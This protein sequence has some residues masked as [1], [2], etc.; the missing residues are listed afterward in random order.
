M[1]AAAFL[2]QEC[3]FHNHRRDIHQ[4]AQFQQI[5]ADDEIDEYYANFIISNRWIRRW[6]RSSRFVVRTIPT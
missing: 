5:V 2:A 4:I 3:T 6:A 1:Q